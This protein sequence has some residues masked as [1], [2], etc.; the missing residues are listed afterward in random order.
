MCDHDGLD[1][2]DIALAG[3]L[4]EQIAQAEKERERLRP[5]VEEEQEKN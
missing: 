2:D 4:A 1:W 3:A 5:E